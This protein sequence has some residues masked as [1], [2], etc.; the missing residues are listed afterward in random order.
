MTVTLPDDLAE[1][2][3][4]RAA[5]GGFAGTDEYIEELVH[6]DDFQA[7]WARLTPEDREA[8]REFE[9]MIDAAEA[10]GP[11]IDGEESYRRAMQWLQDRRPENAAVQG[12]T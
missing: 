4:K 12:P 5:E 1:I 2:I 7:Y 9:R 3:R 8:H 6:Q 10:S 11:P